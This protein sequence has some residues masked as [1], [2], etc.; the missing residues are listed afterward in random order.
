[1]DLLSYTLWGNT[2]LNYLIFISLVLASYLAAWIFA[3]IFEK[4][5]KKVYEKT[6][7]KLDDII[8]LALKKPIKFAIFLAGIY[9]SLGYIILSEGFAPFKKT[10]FAILWSITFAWAAH[11]IVVGLID[12]Y[13]MPKAEKKQ[14]SSAHQFIPI[15]KRAVLAILWVIAAIFILNNAGINVTSLVAGVGIGGIAIAFA[16]QSILE[17]MFSSFSI[18]LDKPFEVGD[19]IVIGTDSGT[20]KKIGVKSTRLQTLQ[21]QEL[22]MSNKELT[23]ARVQNYK[24]MQKRRVVMTLGVVYGTKLNKLKKIP[25]IITD[26]FKSVKKADLLRVHFIEFG[27]FALK[28]ELVFHITSQDYDI[29][30]DTN[31]EINFKIVEEFEKAKLEIAYPTQTLYVK[32]A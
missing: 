1:M 18:Y 24:K 32:K 21:G 28:Y 2:V 12:D 27:D 7:T 26:I 22:I 19:F 14:K 6:K 9:F 3:V 23:N 5:I 20:V 17:D 11:K 25:E 13:W 31:Q 30:R 16:L 4:I 8:F 29:Y 10:I 15:I